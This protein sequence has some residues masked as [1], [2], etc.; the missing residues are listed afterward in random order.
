MGKSKPIKKIISTIIVAALAIIVAF[1]IFTDNSP[2]G[3]G[4]SSFA[5]DHNIKVTKVEFSQNNNKLTLEKKGDAWVVNDKYETRE[6]GINFIEKVITGIEIKSPVSESTFKKEI[7]DKNIEPIKV[8]VYEGNKVVRS[9]LVYKTDSN[10]YGNIMRMK[11][12]SKPFIVNV[13]GY[14]TNIGYA[15][16]LNENYWRPYTLFNFLP[17]EISEVSLSNISDP[18]YSFVITNNNGKYQMSSQGNILTGWDTSRV[19]RYLTYFSMVPFESWQFD[20][21]EEALSEVSGSPFINI[22]VNSTADKNVSV[23]FWQKKTNGLIDTDRLWAKFDDND[24]YVVVKYY[25]IDP[26]LKRNSYFFVN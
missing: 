22:S 18:E 12:N 25:D 21:D 14:E 19:E 24:N 16:T 15:F 26:I 23:N 10:I 2:F 13:P 17:S 7:T 9:F 11:A 20:L 3:K 4:N 8:K 1:L 5:V 6:S